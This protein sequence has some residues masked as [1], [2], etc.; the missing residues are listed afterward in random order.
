MLLIDRIVL[1]LHG[2]LH[3]SEIGYPATALRLY[4]LLDETSERLHFL[5]YYD[6]ACIFE[7]AFARWYRSQPW[8][9]LEYGWV[10]LLI[11]TGYEL[12]W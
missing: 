12:Y 9:N 3:A 8:R 11:E 10:A 6:L 7:V 2:H 4:S 5:R 1:L